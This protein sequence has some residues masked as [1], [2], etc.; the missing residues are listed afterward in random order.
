[1]CMNPEEWA[2]ADGDDEL[3]PDGRRWSAREQD[4]WEETWE[5]LGW[6]D[7]WDESHRRIR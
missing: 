1:M 3:A 6:V 4:E 2:D 5:V 7:E